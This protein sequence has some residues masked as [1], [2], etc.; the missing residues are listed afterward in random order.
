MRTWHVYARYHNFGDYALGLGLRALFEQHFVPSVFELHDAH[1]SS[2]EAAHVDAVNSR[3]DLLLVGGGG[4]IRGKGD[5]WLFQ[6]PDAVIPR[7][8]VPMIFYGLGYNN[9]PGEP[10]ISPAIVDNLRR[11]QEHALAFSVRNDGSQERLARLGLEFREVPDPGFFV[12]G[13]YPPPSLPQP[14]VVVQLAHAI[15]GV[16]D[17]SEADLV[18]GLVPVARQLLQRGY[19]LLLAPHVARDEA[20]SRALMEALGHPPEISMWPWHHMLRDE[21]TRE[22]LAYYKHAAFVI[23]M[24]GHSQICPIGLGVPVITVVSHAKHA[25]LLDRLGLPPYVA[26]VRAPDLAGELTELCRVVEAERAALVDQYQATLRH[27]HAT[28]RQFIEPLSRHFARAS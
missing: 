21:N 4:L 28:A 11:L 27:L 26:S 1:T 6:M 17:Y 2:F 24:R 3:A 5:R 10:D 19:H 18:A 25:G 16:R 23:G 15:S 13:D 8:R 20:P 9:F 7:V 12:D 22:G 14:Y